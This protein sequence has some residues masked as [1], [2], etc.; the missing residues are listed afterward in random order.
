M[1]IAP[2]VMCWII[3]HPCSENLWREVEVVRWV[4]ERDD[5]GDGMVALREGWLVSGEDLT[6]EVHLC[7]GD[8]FKAKFNTIV[9]KP[10]ALLPIRGDENLFKREM[11]ESNIH[12]Y[13]RK[14]AEV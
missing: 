7:S 1:K 6:S 13:T 11:I 12:K 8:I 2:G 5:L 14:L 10:S 4:N 9:C 3:S